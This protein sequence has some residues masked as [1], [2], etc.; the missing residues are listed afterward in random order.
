MT[1]TGSVST[2]E[3]KQGGLLVGKTRILILHAG[4]LVFCSRSFR[5]R[6]VSP[7]FRSQVRT[8]RTLGMW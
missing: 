2:P 3:G 6:L 1:A 7:L 5:V 8:R 4:V